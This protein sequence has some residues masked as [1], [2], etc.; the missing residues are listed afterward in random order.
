MYLRKELF[1]VYFIFKGFFLKKRIF[2]LP[3]PTL[4]IMKLPKGF[5]TPYTGMWQP[6]RRQS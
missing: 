2:F 5:H 4:L 3:D 1:F 6:N